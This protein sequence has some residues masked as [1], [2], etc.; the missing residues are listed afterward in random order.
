MLNQ[1]GQVA[2]RPWRRPSPESQGRLRITADGVIC[3]ERG[4]AQPRA[5]DKLDHPI[6]S[7]AFLAMSHHIKQVTE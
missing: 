3:P 6:G 5:I 2:Q 4:H 1:T 7:T